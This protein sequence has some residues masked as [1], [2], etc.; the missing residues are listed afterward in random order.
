MAILLLNTSTSHCELFLSD[1][2]EMINGSWEA[3][4][5]LAHDLLRHI[6]ELLA[7]RG[8]TRDELTGIGI[9]KGPGSFTGLRIGITVAN[10]LAE[11][12][13]IPIV[14]V[15]DDTLWREAAKDR[16]QAGENDL[17]V[18]PEYGSAAHIT[19]PRK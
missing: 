10:T 19:A 8:K 16:L 9:V 14:G 3:G 18:L 2:D 15:A 12:K 1:G 13:G 5:T 6:D 7:S 17:I 4:R 11:A